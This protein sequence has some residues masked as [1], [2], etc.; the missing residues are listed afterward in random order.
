M[1]NLSLWSRFTFFVLSFLISHCALAAVMAEMP[2]DNDRI[3]LG[4]SVAYAHENRTQ[5]TGGTTDEIGNITPSTANVFGLNN[6]TAYDSYSIGAFLWLP[7]INW[8][9][10]DFNAALA[11]DHIP[12]ANVSAGVLGQSDHDGLYIKYHRT[13]ASAGLNA[14]KPFGN[15]MFAAITLSGGISRYSIRGENIRIESGPSIDNAHSDHPGVHST[16]PF[17]DIKLA[18]GKKLMSKSQALLFADYTVSR[19]D[20]PLSLAAQGSDEMRIDVL[21]P[22]HWFQVGIAFIR[23]LNL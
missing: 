14:V 23:E 2:E 7:M 6:K 3:K 4:F 1:K 13:N 15:D 10:I 17:V 19:R 8:Y 16:T 5:I 12:G 11:L 21:V 20:K 22:K 9:G 18:L